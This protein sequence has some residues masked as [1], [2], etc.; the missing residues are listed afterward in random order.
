VAVAAFGPDLSAVE[1]HDV[2]DDGEAES[3]AAGFAGAGFIEAIEPF[4][5]AL[6][7]IGREAG[8]VVLDLDVDGLGVGFG[9]GDGDVSGLA[10]VLDGV[11]DQVEEHLLKPVGIGSDAE[12]RGDVV[13]QG[14]GAFTGADFEVGDDPVDDGLELDGFDIH[15]DL[16][17]LEAGDGEE[18]FDEV[19]EA[20]GVSLDRLE[21]AGGGGGVFDGAM[22]EGFGVALDHGERGAE[23][24]ADIG[25]ELASGVLKLAEAGEVMADEDDALVLAVRVEQGGGVELEAAA[26][27]SGQFDFGVKHLALGEDALVELLEAIEVEGFEEGLALEIAFDAEELV[28]GLVA[29]AD[30]ALGVEQEDPFDH[31]IEEGEFPGLEFAVGML[32]LVLEGGEVGSGAGELLVNPV[33][34]SFPEPRGDRD[35]E[36]DQESPEG[37]HGRTGQASTKR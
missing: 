32:L 13:L 21:E 33:A 29:E 10:A 35:G 15:D 31:A 22:E 3:G 12:L 23:F 4:E 16:T 11:V 9:G 26:F 28:E 27:R 1:L 25:D 5:D 30:S 18:I 20:V 34:A 8:A 6:Q 14:D 19:G 2:F 24:M 7:G 37:P 17:G 36:E